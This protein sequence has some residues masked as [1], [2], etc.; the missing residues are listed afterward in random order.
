MGPGKLMTVICM[1]GMQSEEG[2]D[3]DDPALG[4]QPESGRMVLLERGHLCCGSPQWHDR[5]GQ[6]SLIHDWNSAS[7]S[8]QYKH[9]IQREISRPRWVNSL[10]LYFSLTILL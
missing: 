10:A 2:V 6:N 7:F 8:Q 9:L 3:S 4:L 1:L 5:W